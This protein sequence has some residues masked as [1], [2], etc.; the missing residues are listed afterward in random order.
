ME[1]LTKNVC[2]ISKYLTKY[3][4]DKIEKKG[5]KITKEEFLTYFYKE[6]VKYEPMKRLFRLIAKPN[7]N[8]IVR[9]DFKKLL[10]TLIDS[11]PGLQFLKPTVEFHD[12]Y[13]L[14]VIERIF[15][16]VDTNDD[17][18]ISFREFKISNLMK[19]INM[20]D[21]EEDINKVYC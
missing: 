6:I 11:H 16:D 19:T 14:T 10:F 13:T 12:K 21:E 9:D 15:Y 18:I 17:R 3:V 4:Y 1:D 20:L 5:A 8:E 7:K 2:G